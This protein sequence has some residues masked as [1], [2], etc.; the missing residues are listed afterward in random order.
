MYRLLIECDQRASECGL[1]EQ[2]SMHLGCIHAYTVQS[3]SYSSCYFKT[4]QLDFMPHLFDIVMSVPL[5]VIVYL[6]IF[7]GKST[8][9]L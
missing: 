4:G 2:I 9:S 8:L 1:S 6:L 3:Y 7:L 5:S